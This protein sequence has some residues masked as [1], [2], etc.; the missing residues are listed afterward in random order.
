MSSL[1]HVLRQ[2]SA[3][4][5]RPALALAGDRTGALRGYIRKQLSSSSESSFQLDIE[6]C[7]SPGITI[8]FGASGAGKT[9]LMDCIA[10]L[11]S[12]ESGEVVLGNKVFFNSK[13]QIDVSPGKRKIAYVFQDLSLF[14]HMSVED[15][16]QYGIAGLPPSE[17]RRRTYDLLESFHIT[18]LAK[19]YPSKLSGGERQRVALARALVTEPGLL[20]L[21]EPMSG[22]DASIKNC[23]IKDLCE[24]NSSRPIPILY[25]TH[26]RK[27]VFALGERIVVLQKGRVVADG[28]PQE[29][30][31]APRQETVAELVG[32]ENVFDAEV[33]ATNE[34]FG[35]MTCQISDSEVSL[36]VPLAHC[37]FGDRVRVAV[38]AGDI[39]LAGESPRAIS[40]RNVFPG[41][42]ISLRRH[43]YSMEAVVDCGVVF[44][45]HLTLGACES[46]QLVPG[47]AVWILIKTH[48]CCLLRPSKEPVAA[49]SSRGL[50]TTDGILR[51][52]TFAP[53]SV[54]ANRN[55]NSH[56]AAEIKMQNPMA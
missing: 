29:V 24:R 28:T 6:F 43:D 47:S 56:L 53:G 36:E 7:F 30:L 21:D 50:P 33:V 48:S 20:L 27:E 31:S 42:L 10:G 11:A 39:M 18:S 51:D 23:I 17:R 52:S 5:Q 4:Q 1:A 15:N 22:L 12:P 13:A 54:I 45:S 41:K 19:S 16:V 8:V 35:V 9:T 37:D 25:V 32:F 14:P 38:R 2:V 46:L 34:H 44:R 40:T 3:E 49:G 55:A 26:S